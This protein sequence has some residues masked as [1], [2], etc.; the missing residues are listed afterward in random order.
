[1]AGIDNITN[2]IL[3][4]AKERAAS[5]TGAATKKADNLLA[6]AKQQGEEFAAKTAEKAKADAAAYG[7]RILSQMGLR[8]RQALLRAKQEI[9]TG[10]IDAAYEKLHSLG[11][12]EYFAMIMLVD[13]TNLN[14]S[15]DQLQENLKKNVS[16]MEIHVMHEDIFN[17]M[18]RI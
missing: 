10:V 17:S 6:Q 2:E 12:K 13:I 5:V 16:D 1:M 7:E 18:H 9:I 14:I 11:D 4:E 15:L 3:Q 8:K